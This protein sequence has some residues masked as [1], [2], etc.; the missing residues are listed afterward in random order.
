MTHKCI[1]NA[2]G[3]GVRL[4]FLSHKDPLVKPRHVC[5]LV[6]VGRDG[7]RAAEHKVG[8]CHD[9]LVN[10]HINISFIN[11]SMIY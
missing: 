2:T 11:I 1:R 3:P 4:F 5:A 7:Q 10:T 6:V 9:G 8:T